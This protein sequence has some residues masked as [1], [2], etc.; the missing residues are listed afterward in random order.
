MSLQALTMLSTSCI[1]LSGVSLLVGWYFIRARRDMTR[2]RN[3]MLTATTFAGLFLVFYVTRWALHGSKPFPGTGAWRLFYFAN[4]LPHVVLAMA[5]GPM[6]MRLIQLALRKRD[7][8]AHRRLARITLPIWL[9]V[10]G[11]GWLIYYLLYVKT[12]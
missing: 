2:H 3:A 7:Y 8:R 11:S 4:L 6:A 1:V 9:Y 10:A 12:Y 5:V